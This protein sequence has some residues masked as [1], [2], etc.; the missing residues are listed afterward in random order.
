MLGLCG[1]SAN[2]PK[3]PGHAP[4]TVVVGLF[5]LL[6]WGDGLWH[7]VESGWSCGLRVR[8]VTG[9]GHRRF[10]RPCD[11]A[12]TF[13]QWKCPAFSFRRRRWTFQLCNR[14]G[15]ST[16]DGGEGFFRRIL[17]HFSRSSGCPGVERQFF[18]LSSTHNCECSRA[19]GVPESLGV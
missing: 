6:V 1:G 14:E 3:E 16:Y 7:G 17:R 5:G 19:P 4:P 10:S 2:E 8:S 15:D 11:H 13:A 18:E 9:A 12:A